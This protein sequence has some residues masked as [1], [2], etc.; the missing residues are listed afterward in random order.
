MTVLSGSPCL[1]DKEIEFKKI[2]VNEKQH[3]KKSLIT[4][5]LEDFVFPLLVYK[6]FKSVII[7]CRIKRHCHVH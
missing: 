7:P 4:Q 2:Y 1:Q 6:I 3:R 5:W